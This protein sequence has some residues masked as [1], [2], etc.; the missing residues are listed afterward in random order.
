MVTVFLSIILEALPFLLLGVFIS[1]VIEVMLR[2]DIIASL[3]PR[4]P[5][6]ALPVAG[7]AGLLFP[8][9]ECGI[10]PI[11]RR[12]HSKGV[13]LGA[14]VT[15]MLAA[16]IVNPVVAL[17]TR[18]AFG[19]NL[20]MGLRLG[21]GFG[22]AAFIGL[23]I[24]LSTKGNVLQEGQLHHHHHPGSKFKAIILTACGE[25]FTMGRYLLL[26]SLLASMVQVYVSRSLLLAVG[27]GN[28]GSVGAMM[29]FGYLLSLCSEA[30][31]FVA[32]TFTGTFTSGSLLAFLLYGPMTDVKNTLMMLAA[33]RTSFVLKLLALITL[34]I[35]VIGLTIN[36]LGVG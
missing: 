30:D 11:T 14:A 9:C 12:L 23:I 35:F 8:V 5:L 28:A 17:S 29:G 7:L 26:G 2:R 34:V 33:F 32:S 22:A 13:P 1:A 4:N 19:N 25:F 31:A 10:V 20:M 36:L 21:A 24:H 3:L 6:V 15:F 16:P 27:Q 18:Y